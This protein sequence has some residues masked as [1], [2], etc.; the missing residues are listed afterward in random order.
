MLSRWLAVP[1]N[2]IAVF[3]RDFGCHLLVHYRWWR[4]KVLPAH[5]DLHREAGSWFFRRLLLVQVSPCQTRFSYGGSAVNILV[6]TSGG[7]P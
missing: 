3:R 1:E 2:G 6:Q 4:E 5:A 7:H